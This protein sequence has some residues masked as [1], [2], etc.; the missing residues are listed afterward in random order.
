MSETEPLKLG[1]MRV[2]D[3][4]TKIYLGVAEPYTWVSIKEAL[5]LAIAGHLLDVMA[6]LISEAED[7]SDPEGAGFADRLSYAVLDEI[8]DCALDSWK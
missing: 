3:G 1:D 2:F 5:R 4:V 8:F 6:D 7:E